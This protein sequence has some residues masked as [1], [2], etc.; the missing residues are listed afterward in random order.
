M[1]IAQALH[2]LESSEIKVLP[3]EQSLR[4]HI[5]RGDPQ[6]V[7]GHPIIFNAYTQSMKGDAQW[8][9]SKP[10][11]DSRQ[12]GRWLVWRDVGHWQAEHMCSGTKALCQGDREAAACTEGEHLPW[13]AEEVRKGRWGQS[14]HAAQPA[15]DIAE[16][17][18]WREEMQTEVWTS[19]RS[20]EG[21]EQKNN[22]PFAG[23]CI[24]R[25]KAKRLEEFNV[26]NSSR[27]WVV[28][29]LYCV[30]TFR[31]KWW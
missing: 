20:T 13:K 3:N 16:W 22:L 14:G 2:G 12:V 4:S 25:R 6:G 31:T 5:P 18:G 21:L 10:A 8:L 9:L 17:Y 26:L 24:L 28:V 29:S 30:S 15:C 1:C 27:K 23:L 7:R 19:S 11:D